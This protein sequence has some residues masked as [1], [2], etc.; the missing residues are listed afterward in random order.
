[1]KKRV[2]F[3]TVGHLA[4]MAGV[5]ELD[6]MVDGTTVRDFLLEMFEHVDESFGKFVLPKGRLN[7]VVTILKNGKNINLLSGLD[8]EIEDGDVISVMHPSIG[9]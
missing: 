6:V 5:K 9:G 2:R 8:T 3:K 1:M 7:D 4:A